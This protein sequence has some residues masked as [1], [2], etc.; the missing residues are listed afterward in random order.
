MSD[1]AERMAEVARLAKVLSNAQQYSPDSPETR[2]IEAS[3]RIAYQRYTNPFGV[4]KYQ[5]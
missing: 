2:S 1:S 5:R 4:D 3:Y